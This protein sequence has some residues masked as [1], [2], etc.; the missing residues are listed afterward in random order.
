MLDDAVFFAPSFRSS[1]RVWVGR[2]RQ[3]RPI[4]D[5]A[6]K[7][8]LYPDLRDK[9]FARRTMNNAQGHLDRLRGKKK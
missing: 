1:T 6:K 5:Y 2:R 8:A 7:K 4:Y 9:A 3:W